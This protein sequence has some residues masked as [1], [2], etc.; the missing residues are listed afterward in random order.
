MNNIEKAKEIG[1]SEA[2]Y[3]S[4]RVSI[5]DLFSKARRSGIYLLHFANNEAYC[6]QAIDVTR[7]FCQHLKTHTDIIHIQFQEHSR[8][9]LNE[10]E[11]KK[12]EELENLKFRLRNISLVTLPIGESDFDLIMN[13]ENQEN[14][15]KNLRYYGERT[16]RMNEPQLR[17]NYKR[18]YQVLKSKPFF[19]EVI[20]FLKEYIK[21]AIPSVE[22][23]EM[24]FWAISCLPSTNAKDETVYSRINL[25]WQEVL[26]V[27]ETDNQVFFSFHISKEQMEKGFG[28]GF[29]KLFFL[30]SRLHYSDHMYAQGGQ[31]Q[32]HFTVYG[33]K[34]ALRFIKEKC[35]QLAIRKFNHRLMKKSACVYSRYHCFDLADAIV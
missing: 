21:V 9:K 28:R 11:K 20:K 18:K 2:L 34:Q 22:R 4:G 31:D 16:Q 26:T 14:W 3:V 1:F 23:T 13:A 17:E 7:R 32:I 33:V 10:V 35:V 15:L 29:R 24:A 30:H 6:G 5:A 19:L 25:G 27:Y 12:I 8:D